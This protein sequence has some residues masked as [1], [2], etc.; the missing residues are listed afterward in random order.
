[1]VENIDYVVCAICGIRR[2]SLGKHI[3]THNMS[4]DDYKV[5]FPNHSIHCSKTMA[6]LSDA[7]SGERNGMFGSKRFGELN[8]FYGKNH[9]LETRKLLS[10]RITETTPRG[11][12]HYLF[13]KGY[14]ISGSNNP[15]YGPNENL[16]GE[17]N[18]FYGRSHT[19]E[20][21]DKLRNDPRCV[22]RG[23]LGHHVSEKNKRLLSKLASE[24]A[25]TF[26]SYYGTYNSLRFDSSYEC[27]FIHICKKLSI[28][29]ERAQKRFRCRY[30]NTKGVSHDYYPDFYAISH[31]CVIEIKGWET[32]NDFKKYESFQREFPHVRFIILKYEHLKKLCINH[33]LSMEFEKYDGISYK[34]RSYKKKKI[35]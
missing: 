11:K 20:V 35:N 12:D 19:Q 32:K 16:K 10:K 34:K 29:L 5:K 13:K 6:K 23:F 31:N 7:R 17:K 15:N 25:N 3:K 1:M 22:S 8:P 33:N 26:T 28:K 4:I 9:S 24:R 21:I 2:L 18:P 30:H 14:L 27:I